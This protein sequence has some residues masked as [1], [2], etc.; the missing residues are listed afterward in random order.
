MLPLESHSVPVTQVPSHLQPNSTV[1]D[2]S[3]SHASNHTKAAEKSVVY[4]EDYEK[5]YDLPSPFVLDSA[6]ARKRRTKDFKDLNTRPKKFSRTLDELSSMQKPRKIPAGKVELA[7]VFLSVE[8]KAILKLVA[9]NYNIFFTGSA[10]MFRWVILVPFFLIDKSGTGKSILLREIIHEL[11]RKYDDPMAIGITASTGI[12]GV[13]IGGLTLH[14]FAGLPGD[15][16]TMTFDRLKKTVTANTGARDRWERLRVLVIDES[17]IFCFF[18]L[19]SSL[20]GTNTVSM[21]DSHTFDMIIKIGEHFGPM[22]NYP[23]GGIQVLFGSIG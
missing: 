16:R 4:L 21:I 15:I 7:A 17:K 23:F 12:A 22:K 8:Q 5:L 20:K 18:A 3:E 19:R 14:Y 1:V 13:N 2:P 10:G 9:S 11:K 6:A